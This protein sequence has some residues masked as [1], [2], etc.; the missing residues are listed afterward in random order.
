MES[1]LT[2]PTAR[3]VHLCV[4][5]DQERYLPK[6]LRAPMV[7]PPD[8]PMPR[9]GEVIYLARNSAWAVAMVIHSWHSIFELRVEL[10]IEFVGNPRHAR[11][12][13]FSL[14]Q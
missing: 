13:G 7:L 1:E 12:V 6:R 8:I 14:T 4:P 3:T 5:D 9:V 10:W 2:V 11:P